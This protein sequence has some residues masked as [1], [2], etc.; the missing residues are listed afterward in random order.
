M[1]PVGCINGRPGNGSTA[2]GSRPAPTPVIPAPRSRRRGRGGARL[3]SEALRQ[4]LCPDRLE[5]VRTGRARPAAR[6]R[7][8]AS[9]REAATHDLSI[10]ARPH[11]TPLVPVARFAFLPALSLAGPFSA[12]GDPFAMV[13]WRKKKS[14]ASRNVLS[15]TS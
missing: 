12:P 4:Q 3:R 5:P 6:S 10:L 15:C 11:P 7:F 9:Q 13:L 14:L 2:T 8:C 1:G